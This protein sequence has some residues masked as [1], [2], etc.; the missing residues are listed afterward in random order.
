MRVIPVWGGPHRTFWAT[1]STSTHR[2]RP[3]AR[4]MG[5]RWHRTVVER[6]LARRPR[7]RWVAR[8]FRRLAAGSSSGGRQARA[9]RT[10][11]GSGRRRARLGRP[12][13]LAPDARPVRA[14]RRAAARAVGSGRPRAAARCRPVEAGRHRPYRAGWRAERPTTAGRASRSRSPPSP[15]PTSRP[16]CST[17]DARAELQHPAGRPRGRRRPPPGDGRP[18][19]RGRPRDSPTCTPPRPRRSRPGSAWPARSLGLAA[20]AH[21]RWA[22]ALSELRAARRMSGHDDQ[23]PRDGRLRARPRPPRAGARARRRRP[24]LARLDEAGRVEMRIVA[25]GA[26]RDLG[27][28]D[29]A[30]A[31]PAGARS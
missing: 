23:L 12:P 14:A 24:R 19:A 9:R 5:P 31:D 21:R 29:A 25:A 30:V 2:C 17:G 28:L 4:G 20:Y 8:R 3:H 27:Q 15:M 13:V 18:P 26:R 10:G 16:R 1:I 22:Q 7:L 6:W 11:S